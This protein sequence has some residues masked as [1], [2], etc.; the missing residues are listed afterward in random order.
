MMPIPQGFSR[1]G[2]LCPLNSVAEQGDSVRFG[3]GNA[4]HGAAGTLTPGC[5]VIMGVIGATDALFIMESLGGIFDT[6]TAR[7]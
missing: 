4:V 7:Q 3:Q 1:G 6:A 5:L 2:L